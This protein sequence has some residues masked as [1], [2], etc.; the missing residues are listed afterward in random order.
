M[1]RD[2]VA[3][4]SRSDTIRDPSI[5]QINLINCQT[6]GEDGLHARPPRRSTFSRGFGCAGLHGS[7][8]LPNERLIYGPLAEL[9]GKDLVLIEED[10]LVDWVKDSEL[11]LLGR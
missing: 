5:P 3:D 2:Q 6:R 1:E 11:A 10:D 7:C 8:H 4:I 9:E